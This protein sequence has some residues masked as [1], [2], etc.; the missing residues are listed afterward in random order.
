MIDRLLMNYGF[1][2][3]YGTQVVDHSFY[4]IRDIK[5]VNKRRK[6]LRLEPIEQ[7]AK[8]F[9]FEFKLSQNEKK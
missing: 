3:I 6:Q 9:G 2:Q 1:E 7:V 4:T 5:N 8:K